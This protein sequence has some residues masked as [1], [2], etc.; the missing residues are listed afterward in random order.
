MVFP[1]HHLGALGTQRLQHFLFGLGT[2][3]ITMITINFGAGQSQHAREITRIRGLY[4]YLQ[5]RLNSRL[6]LSQNC[7]S[8]YLAK[9]ETCSVYNLL[10]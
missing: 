6:G 9:I 4:F 7:G 3:I 1:D 10:G 2:A 8:R 5:H